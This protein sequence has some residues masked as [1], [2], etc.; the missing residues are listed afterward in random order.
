MEN[1]LANKYKRENNFDLLRLIATIAVILLHTGNFFDR[2]YDS[3]FGEFCSVVF[4]IA[5][6]LFLMLS[7]AFIL[8]KKKDT[9]QFYKKALLK[10]GKP[11]LL[12]SIISLIYSYIKFIVLGNGIYISLKKIVIMLL[13]GEPFYHLWYMYMLIGLYLLV[14]VLQ[15]IK[16]RLTEKQFIYF[17]CF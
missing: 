12:V 2:Y 9:L 16:E 1:I 13:I 3:N 4:R 17:S 14:P 7:G 15:Y 10:L 5:V 11:L 8:K 6:P